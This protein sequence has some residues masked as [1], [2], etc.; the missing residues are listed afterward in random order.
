MMQVY[1]KMVESRTYVNLNTSNVK[2]YDVSQSIL[3]H[4]QFYNDATWNVY[5]TR[6][7]DYTYIFRVHL[8]FVS[9]IVSL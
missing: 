5:I 1:F 6:T 3:D 4:V 7:L 2:C 8:L 9:L